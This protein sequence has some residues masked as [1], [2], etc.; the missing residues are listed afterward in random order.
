MATYKFKVG[1]IDKTLP[2]VKKTIILKERCKKCEQN[3]VLKVE[4]TANERQIV[5]AEFKGE[6]G[7]KKCKAT[8]SYMTTVNM[9]RKV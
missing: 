7:N 3:T 9:P 6:C 4:I 1:N 2:I 8:I 5:V